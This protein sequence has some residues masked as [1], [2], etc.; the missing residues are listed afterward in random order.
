MSSTARHDRG[1]VEVVGGGPVVDEPLTSFVSQNAITE[2]EAKVK[3]S[4][5]V[6]SKG[7]VSIKRCKSSADRPR[8]WRNGSTCAGMLLIAV[9]V[10]TA[11][12]AGSATNHVGAGPERARAKRANPSMREVLQIPEGYGSIQTMSG[13]VD[14]LGVW[15]WSASVDDSRVWRYDPVTSST[16]SWSLGSSADVLGGVAKPAPLQHAERRLSS[17]AITD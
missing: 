6:D 11:C 9:L 4:A 1:S 5:T 3:S 16:A 8:C 7:Q 15:V 10:G 13:A 17:A 12:A 14:H 2:A